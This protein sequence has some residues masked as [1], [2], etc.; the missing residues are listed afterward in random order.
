M[1][2][3]ENLLAKMKIF[4]Q[5]GS[6][7]SDAKRV[8]V[9]RDGHALLGRQYGHIV[10]G[11]LVQ[12]RRLRALRRVLSSRN[13]LFVFLVSFIEPLVFESLLLTL[14]PLSVWPGGSSGID[15]GDVT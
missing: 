15:Y 1:I 6:A 2:E 13:R 9:I 10:P 11:S 4:E 8:L 5:R 14:E 7:R 12:L 3:V